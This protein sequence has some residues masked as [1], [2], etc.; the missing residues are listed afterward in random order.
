MVFFHEP[1]GAD[2]SH[3]F[4]GSWAPIRSI[5]SSS[6][7]SN[8]LTTHPPIWRTYP[9]FDQDVG[10][11]QWVQNTEVSWLT[12]LSCL[13]LSTPCN[14]VIL[15]HAPASQKKSSRLA[16]FDVQQVRQRWQHSWTQV[17][18]VS[19]WFMVYHGG[20]ILVFSSKYL[21]KMPA[22][23]TSQWAN[24]TIQRVFVDQKTSW[25]TRCPCHSACHGYH[26]TDPTTCRLWLAIFGWQWTAS[27]L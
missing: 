8:G 14:F 27:G 10:L 24:G 1:S 6:S 12:K 21:Q 11:W 23:A 15:T 7:D 18:M 16:A 26:P 9:S 2:L 4:R 3:S 17:S 22:E 20:R 25:W 5:P 13:V 19:W